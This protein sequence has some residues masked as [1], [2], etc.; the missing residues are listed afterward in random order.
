[1]DD[2]RRVRVSKFISKQLRHAPEELG[3][4]LEAGGWVLV[5]DLL[6]GAKKAGFHFTRPELDR[7]V[8]AC[9]KQRFAFNETG[10]RIR[11]NQGHSTEVHL[12]LNAVEPAGELFHGPHG[13]MLKTSFATVFIK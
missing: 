2:K 5:E 4:V 7:V 10:E 9:D 13:G 1:M 12:Q 8:A 11:A 6:Q 3:L